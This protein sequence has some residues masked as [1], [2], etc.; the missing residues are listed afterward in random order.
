MIQK[1][2]TF[3]S[4]RINSVKIDLEKLVDILES[5]GEKSISLECDDTIYESLEEIKSHKSAISIPFKVKCGET[6]IE[7]SPYEVAIFGRSS[8]SHRQKAL[9]KEFAACVPMLSKRPFVTYFT[10]M[11]LVSI[12]LP[13]LFDHFTIESP[14]QILG[15][16]WRDIA[17]FSTL[18][19]SVMVATLLYY[20][21]WSRTK[22]YSLRSGFWMRHKEQIA[23]GIIVGLI[24][25]LISFFINGLPPV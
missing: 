22:V 18:I 11:L 24:M 20:F 5:T 8:S 15:L 17:F 16:D 21:H 2:D 9:S 7:F 13:W 19:P 14:T 3:E 6:T 23:V 25:L 4:I 10:I 12:F 1:V